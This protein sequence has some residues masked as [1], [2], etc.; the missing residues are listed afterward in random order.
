MRTSIGTS[1]IART[2]GGQVVG[3][4]IA[5]DMNYELSIPDGLSEKF[6]PIFELLAKLDEDLIPN[7]DDD[8]KDNILDE[9]GK[10][11]DDCLLHM[12]IGAVI[13]GVSKGILTNQTKFITS[14]MK[15]RG[16]Y[17]AMCEATGPISQHVTANKLGYTPI[18]SID[19]G[20]FEYN[21]RK[22]FASLPHNNR[23]RD[24]VPCESCV[25]MIKVM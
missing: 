7:L 8:L 10:I 3:L 25:M 9:N 13:P 15:Q 24:G 11:I 23:S 16:Y 20:D 5:H 1:S 12:L 18:A 22:P 2:G 4:I 19:Y 6:N 17:A 21:G 14:R